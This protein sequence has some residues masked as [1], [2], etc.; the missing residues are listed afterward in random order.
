MGIDIM[1]RNDA[2]GSGRIGQKNLSNDVDFWDENQMPD[3]VKRAY[4]EETER[5]ME[6]N[7]GNLRVNSSAEAK[8]AQ[9]RMR[10]YEQYRKD[11]S[12][13][14]KTEDKND[15][16]IDKLR[17]MAE[18]ATDGTKKLAEPEINLKSRFS[19]ITSKL[20]DTLGNMFDKNND[21]NDYD[22]MND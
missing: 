3:D 21:D 17:D 11:L 6:E 12:I 18:N 14:D 15:S 10:M 8:E 19:N 20:G 9:E 1:P 4:I 5:L 13:G 7:G 22:P 2:L 16:I